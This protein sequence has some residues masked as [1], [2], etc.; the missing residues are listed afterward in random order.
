[1]LSVTRM[2]AAVQTGSIRSN[3][4]EGSNPVLSV[5]LTSAWADDGV[6]HLPITPK[7]CISALLPIPRPSKQARLPPRAVAMGF[8][9]SGVGSRSE[10]DA[11]SV[12]FLM[13][14]AP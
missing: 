14:N 5:R 8:S 10:H 12:V 11:S 4:K 6:L 2:A 3:P 7:L 13:T 9:H 1:M